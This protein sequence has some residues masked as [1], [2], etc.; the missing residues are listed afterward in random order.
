MTPEQRAELQGISDELS[1]AM[2]LNPLVR[3]LGALVTRIMM[4]ERGTS[5]VNVPVEPPRVAA[6]KKTKKRRGA[7]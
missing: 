3:R 5:V 6:R 7:A 4:G 2:P 1:R